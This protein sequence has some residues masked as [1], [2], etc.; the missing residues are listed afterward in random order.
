MLK[1][2]LL[3]IFICYLVVPF[4]GICQTPASIEADLLKSLKKI[5]YWRDYS[6]QPHNGKTT[7]SP[8]DSLAKWNDDFELKLK[9][10]TS[11]YPFT[12]D[13]KFSLLEKN[14]VDIV[15]SSDGKF[16]IYSWDTWLGG[17]QHDFENVFQY[18]VD[19]KTISNYEPAD[20]VEEGRPTYWFSS[21]FTLKTKDKTYYLGAYNGI[22]STKDAGQGIK[23]YAI[24]NGRLNDDVKIIK[25]Q[26]GLHNKIYYDYD[27]FSVVD[28]KVRPSI[29][30]DPKTETIHIPVVEANGK[31]THGYIIYK[32]TGEYFERVKN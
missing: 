26:S 5:H 9:R 3:F 15:S 10:Y 16:R 28:W 8:D 21:L 24:E 27:F 29:Y 6:R 4:A 19:N 11:L 1:K 12:I 31:V 20:S 17:T 14:H 7:V 13:Q 23:V 22:Y 2:F 32:F 30:F 18:K 25:T